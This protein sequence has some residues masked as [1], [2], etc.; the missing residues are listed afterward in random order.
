MSRELPG[1]TAGFAHLHKEATAPGT[2]GSKVKELMALAIAVAIHCEDCIAYH[3]HDALKAGATRGEVLE[4]LGVAIMMG[5]GP[6]L[7]Y[8]CE[9]FEALQQYEDQAAKA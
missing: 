3:V 7:M 9:A 5:G 1:A 8:A 6:A 4:T 2:L